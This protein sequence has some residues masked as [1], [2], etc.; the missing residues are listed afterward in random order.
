MRLGRVAMLAEC[1]LLFPLFPPSLQTNE[2]RDVWIY[3]KMRKYR[4][5][6]MLDEKDDV[7]CQHVP[8]PSTLM[9]KLGR[10]RT[11]PEYPRY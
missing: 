3:L 4:I 1:L 8:M 5:K 6:K 2:A 9:L 10:I 11:S 7:P